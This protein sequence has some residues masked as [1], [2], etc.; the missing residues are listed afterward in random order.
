M[1]TSTAVIL[2]GFVV[3]SCHALIMFK[4]FNNHSRSHQRQKGPIYTYEQNIVIF[5]NETEFEKCFY[6][7]D[8]GQTKLKIVWKQTL[9]KM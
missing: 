2:L 1:H 3:F 9:D 5:L 4:D 6:F 7:Q 8:F